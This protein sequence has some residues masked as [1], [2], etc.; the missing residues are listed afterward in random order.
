MFSLDDK[1]I[2][3]GSDEKTVQEWNIETG[4]CINTY[5]G[6]EDGITSIALS[7]DGRKIA[8]V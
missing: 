8:A 1:S 3:T 2:F 7:P 5:N 4:E 6:P